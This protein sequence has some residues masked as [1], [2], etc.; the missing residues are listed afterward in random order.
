MPVHASVHA[1]RR[2]SF[3]VAS[4]KKLNDLAGVQVHTRDHGS[5]TRLTP[6]AYL[7]LHEHEWRHVAPEAN[8]NDDTHNGGAIMNKTIY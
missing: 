7:H 8:D 6:H 5:I 3:W 1:G 2:V 4:T